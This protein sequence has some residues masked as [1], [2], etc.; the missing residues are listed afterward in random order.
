M[1]IFATERSGEAASADPLP[2]N[3]AFRSEM[4]S[5]VMARNSNTLPPTTLH[6]APFDRSR[7][8]HGRSH[9]PG[10]A[11]AVDSITCRS[12]DLPR[13]FPLTSRAPSRWQV[14]A[15]VP[16]GGAGQRTGLG[17]V[18]QRRLCRSTRPGICSSSIARL[19]SLSPQFK[20]T[21]SV[22]SRC[23]SSL[24]CSDNHQRPP[25]R[26]GRV[27]VTSAASIWGQST[28]SGLTPQSQ[29]QVE[30]GAHHEHGLDGEV[31]VDRVAAS[32]PL[33][34]AQPGGHGLFLD[35]DGDV[36]APAQCAIVGRPVSHD[37][38]RAP[39]GPRGRL[40]RHDIFSISST[41]GCSDGDPTR[42]LPAC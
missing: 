1:T 4:R 11:F 15:P 38:A 21:E 8:E 41:L 13:R 14:R 36:A 24:A 29:R 6:T 12:R 37:V 18:A 2:S 19:V 39:L 30:D 40:A 7:Q 32:G 34:A 23:D 28:A 26:S 9:Q 22:G 5:V 33:V 35:P 10:R 31:G 42:D 20:N 17:A 16:R 27:T 3:R 25:Q